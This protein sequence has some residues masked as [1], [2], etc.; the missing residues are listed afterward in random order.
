MNRMNRGQTFL[1]LVFLI[2]GIV[3]LIGFT[4]AFLA[5]SFIDTGYGYQAS[6]QAEAVA[7]SGV[8]D[9]LLQLDRVSSSSLPGSYTIP[10]GSNTATVT[11]TQNVPSAGLITLLS[12]AT[13]SSHTRKVNVVAAINAA[14]NQVSVVS[15]QDVQ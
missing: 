1:A 4:L 14:T 10:V 8:E 11:V 9:A 6:V 3:L 12:A 5:N 2:G 15:W 13:V 7:I